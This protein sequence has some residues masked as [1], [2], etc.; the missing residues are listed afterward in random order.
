MTQLGEGTQNWEGEGDS[1]DGIGE[2]QREGESDLSHLR[3]IT[4]HLRDTIREK[5]ESS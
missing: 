4:G 3:G 5:D 2:E 1:V